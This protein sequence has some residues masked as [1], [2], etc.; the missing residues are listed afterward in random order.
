ML[1]CGADALYG[2]PIDT[3]AP[4]N[5]TL[6]GYLACVRL[7][8]S[9]QLPTL[10]LGGGGYNL[11]NTARLWTSIVAQL[12]GTPELIDTDIPDHDPYFLQYA[13][14]YEMR[15]EPGCHRNKNTPEYTQK[16]LDTVLGNLDMIKI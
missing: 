5:L 10:F 12:V 6:D 4:F 3:E 8:M 14:S 13:P 7:V 9:A 2:D 1:Q 15:V 11:A 16:I